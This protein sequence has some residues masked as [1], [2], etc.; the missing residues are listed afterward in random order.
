VDGDLDEAPPEQ[1]LG[2]DQPVLTVEGQCHEDLV[3]AVS[4]LALQ[5]FAA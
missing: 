1:L 3:L 4:D 5:V 2:G